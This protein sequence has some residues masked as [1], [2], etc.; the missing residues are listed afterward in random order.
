MAHIRRYFVMAAVPLVLAASLAAQEKAD[1]VDG[2]S[3]D[4]RSADGRNIAGLEAFVAAREAG[5]AAERQA[6]VARAAELGLP[7]RQ[8]LVDGT[9]IELARFTAEGR[10]LYRV[11]D[12]LNAARTIS[13][14]DVWAGGSAGLS[15][16]GAGQSLAIWDGGSVRDTHQELTGR[17]TLVESVALS[18]HS[19]HVAGTMIATGVT[20]AARGMA[21]G[22][23]LR[24]W[25]FNTDETEMAAAQAGGTPPVISNHSYGYISG[26]NNGSFGCSN[27]A[28]PQWYFFGDVTVS[29]QEDLI[30]GLYEETAQGWDQIVFDS[31][32]YLI[33]K[34]A[35]NDRGDGPA[36]QPV[37]HCQWNGTLNGGQGDFEPS[38]AVHP[39]DGGATGFDTIGG[40]AG[41]AKNL[42]TVGAVNDI[43]GGYAGPSSVVMSTFSGW[44]PVDDGRIKPDV[45]ANGVSLNSSTST[46]NTSYGNLSGTSMSTPNA[47]GSA[48]L[49][50]QHA[51]NL[52]QT[53]RA[54]TY[55]AL[56]LHTAD[57][58]GTNPGPDYSF[59]WGLM[60]TAAAT[61]VISGQ[62]ATHDR[63][64]QGSLADGAADTYLIASDGSQPLR[65]TLVWTDPP[66]PAAPLTALDPATLRLVND[67]DLRAT[68]PGGGTVFPWVLDPA[69]PAA[70]ATT[71]DNDR[72]NVEQI[73]IA[74]PAA[75]TYTF[76]VNHEG[77]ITSGPQAYS[78]VFTGGSAVSIFADGFES[79]STAGWSLT[80]P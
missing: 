73:L 26:W 54:A 59:G 57:E 16:N 14:D 77:S 39:L 46:S 38:T 72:D 60:N 50:R 68:A 9:V 43:P 80:V 20:A 69:N 53:W 8:E 19:T 67:L 15:L 35:G 28:D 44:G 78:L 62:A 7:L 70:A 10:P 36:T 76:T 1:A 25:D 2:R 49:L 79:G 42:I 23:T 64:Y 33:F 45:V 48:A 13:T 18:A 51:A 52:G 11:T 41:S 22:A 75:G 74:T 24:S 17:V 63:I 32:D 71:G 56:I 55:K 4:G 65:A 31:P 3:A 21:N 12:N 5:A 27:G 47:S 34:S 58:A 30:F 37:A 40:G 29:S 61:L 6:T 66:G